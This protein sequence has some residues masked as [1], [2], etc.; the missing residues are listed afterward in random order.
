MWFTWSLPSKVKEKCFR[1]R[2][3][4]V[5][6]SAAITFSLCV[7]LRRHVQW[8]KSFIFYENW[9]YSAAKSV[10]SCRCVFDGGSV[11][12]KLTSPELYGNERWCRTAATNQKDH[13]TDVSCFAVH[14]KR[15]WISEQYQGEGSKSSKSEAS[16]SLGVN[17]LHYSCVNSQTGHHQSLTW[18]LPCSFVIRIN[19]APALLLYNQDD[20]HWWWPLSHSHYRWLYV[21]HL[22]RLCHP[23]NKTVKKMWKQMS[24]H[25]GGNQ[26]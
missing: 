1:Q 15:L 11:K 6:F 7:N 20:N 9:C 22:S 10:K 12:R 26:L 24:C 8:R 14:P 5:D 2:V 3:I 18:L 4:Y 25:K 23:F 19:V 16:D 13:T 17:I 21:A